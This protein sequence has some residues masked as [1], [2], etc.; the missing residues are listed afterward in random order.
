MDKRSPL[1]TDIS[2]SADKRRRSKDRGMS[3]A[4]SSGPRGCEWPGCEEKAAYRAPKSPENLNEFRWFCL[5]H[6]RLYNSR[7]NYYKNMSEEE[8]VE[9]QRTD[10]M[11]GRKT[12]RLGRPGASEGG[13]PHADGQAWRRFG[14][15]D[16]HDVLGDKATLN[17]GDRSAEVRARLLPKATLKALKTMS[18]E[19]TATRQEIR[20]RYKELVKRF[21]PDQNGGDR[22]E[23][24]R[25][26]E[27]L[28]AW[29]ILKNDSSFSE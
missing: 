14:F 16:P 13:E 6:V 8:I 17:P 4:V 25:L 7:W 29:E 5:E 19:V 2:V 24:H 21:H 11:W 20:L 22:S 9:S 3:G 18:L 1:F 27:V 15:E 28:A 26:R 10:K 12:W 23:E